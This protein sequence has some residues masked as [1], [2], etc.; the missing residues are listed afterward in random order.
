[1]AVIVFLDTHK[2]QSWILTEWM[3]LMSKPILS[4][5]FKN[6]LEIWE[7]LVYSLF[8][9]IFYL[10]IHISS[11]THFCLE[12]ELFN[13][14]SQLPKSYPEFSLLPIPWC[15]SHTSHATHLTTQWLRLVPSPVF[16]VS[17]TVSLIAFDRARLTTTHMACQEGWRSC[18]RPKFL[19]A[20]LVF[21]CLKKPLIENNMWI[22][23]CLKCLQVLAYIV[24]NPR[25][26]DLSF[27]EKHNIRENRA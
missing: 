27:L 15:S 1:M 5:L 17:L 3:N 13:H 4:G 9:P 24:S 21:L 11:I 2:V 20:D 18:P 23:T 19:V 10:T 22:L 16:P 14:H 6:K 25:P 26:Q 12:I 8:I 7:V